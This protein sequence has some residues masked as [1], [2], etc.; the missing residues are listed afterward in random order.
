[1]SLSNDK[2]L[3]ILSLSEKILQNHEKGDGE[4]NNLIKEYGVKCEDVN[5]YLQQLLYSE[6]KQH[7]NK[8]ISDYLATKRFS[9]IVTANIIQLSLNKESGNL[10][11]AL[12]YLKECNKLLKELARNKEVKNYIKTE[13]KINYKKAFVK[14]INYSRK[15]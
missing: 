14:K 15:I 3:K 12:K 13:C 4:I 1:M 5:N 10:E 7:A 6:S 11:E 9:K 8:E 2:K